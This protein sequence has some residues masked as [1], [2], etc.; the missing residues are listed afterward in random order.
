MIHVTQATHCYGKIDH[1]PGLFY[2]VTQFNC[3]NGIPVDPKKSYLVYDDGRERGVKIR[4]RWKSVCFAWF[5]ALMLLAAGSF[6]I[7][8]AIVAFGQNPDFIAGI[9]WVVLAVCGLGLF[10]GSY[11]IIRIGRDEA[12][13]I[14]EEAGLDPEWVH[15]H[16]DRLEGQ[17]DS[18]RASSLNM[19]IAE[20]ER[21]YND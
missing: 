4:F 21:R 11:C 15:D 18:S 2:V 20:M 7:F 1:V 3:A 16:F 13:R 5:R 14:A 19:D 17:S 6:P 9:V 12:A 10:F 8:G